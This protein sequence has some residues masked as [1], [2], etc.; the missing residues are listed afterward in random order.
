[1]ISL[2]EQKKS[3]SVSSLLSQ[4]VLC[5]LVLLKHSQ[6]RAMTEKM[7]E[8]TTTNKHLQIF[9]V[10]FLYYFK[11]MWLKVFPHCVSPNIFIRLQ[12]KISRALLILAL[13][14]Q[15]STFSQPH[16]IATF[17]F[18]LLFNTFRLQ[19]MFQIVLA[20]RQNVALL[21][22]CCALF[23]FQLVFI[24][25]QLNQYSFCFFSQLQENHSALSVHTVFSQ[26][27]KFHQ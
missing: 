12:K 13:L 8:T 17:S 18:Q 19:V 2:P 11:P 14:H 6:T 15:S 16:S 4:K 5:S 3:F 24:F 25:F 21:A 23:S 10:H 1:M 27:F 22:R 26:K 7:P 20:F 9:F